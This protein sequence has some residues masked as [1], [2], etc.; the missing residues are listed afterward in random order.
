VIWLV[1]SEW[2]KTIN[3]AE[4]RTTDA[5]HYGSSIA[6]AENIPFLWQHLHENEYHK[7][8]ATQKFQGVHFNIDILV[9]KSEFI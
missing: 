2:S 3:A 7:P 1:K 6:N 9:V 8:L 4:T 5:F